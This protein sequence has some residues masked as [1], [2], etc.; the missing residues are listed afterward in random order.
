LV[1]ACMIE[2]ITDIQI[3][4]QRIRVLSEV[5]REKNLMTALLM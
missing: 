4:R 2:G 5:N 1:L 3:K